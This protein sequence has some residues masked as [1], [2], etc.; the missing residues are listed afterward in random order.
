MVLLQGKGA[1]WVVLQGKGVNVGVA[2][3]YNMDYGKAVKK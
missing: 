3:R 1:V 2:P